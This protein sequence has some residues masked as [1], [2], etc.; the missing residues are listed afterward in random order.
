MLQQYKSGDAAAL[1]TPDERLWL[2]RT[3]VESATHPD[4]GEVIPQP[5]RMSGFVV[6]G[7]PICLGMLLPNPATTTV[8]FWQACN[9]SHNALVNWFNRNASLNTPSS[10]FAMG[11]AGAVTS[12][13]SVALLFRAGVRRLPVSP[14]MRSMAGR[15]AAF[16]AV[17]SANCVN[18]L[19]VRGW[20][21]PACARL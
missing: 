20:L 14:A 19:P 17:I 10:A 4:T 6:Y 7:F 3:V 5:L 15:F 12:A 8:A 1:Q 2:A 16:P 21:V 13:V 11:F 18:L 9:Q